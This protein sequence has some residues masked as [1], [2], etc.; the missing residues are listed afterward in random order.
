MEVNGVDPLTDSSCGVATVKE[1][2]MQIVDDIEDSQDG[3]LRELAGGTGK[4]AVHAR[5]LC[6]IK[7]YERLLYRLNS[8][9]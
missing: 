8:C 3:V 4:I 2:L 7:S 1:I 9:D 6:K 5:Q